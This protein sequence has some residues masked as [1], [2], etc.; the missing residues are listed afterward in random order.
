MPSA[1][2]SAAARG[3]PELMKWASV[4]SEA[5]KEAG[6]KPGVFQPGTKKLGTIMRRIYKERYGA[7]PKKK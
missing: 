5:R 7:P 4:M 6:F 2:K 3:N 1:A